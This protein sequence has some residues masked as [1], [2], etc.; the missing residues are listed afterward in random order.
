MLT[1][2]LSLLLLDYLIT[3]IKPAI[4]ADHACHM[5]LGVYGS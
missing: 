2:L 4:Y 1:K 3:L 5:C